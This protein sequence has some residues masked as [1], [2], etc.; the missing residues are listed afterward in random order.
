MSTENVTLGALLIILLPTNH[1]CECKFSFFDSK[2]MHRQKTVITC[3]MVTFQFVMEKHN[4]IYATKERKFDFSNYFA[5]T[6]FQPVRALYN[7][8]FC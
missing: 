7:F 8:H 4:L 1:N 2:R 6:L 3:G 5:F